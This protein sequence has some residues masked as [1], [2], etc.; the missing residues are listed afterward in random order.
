MEKVVIM[1]FQSLPTEMS[2]DAWKDIWEEEL[3]KLPSR[4][5]Y[6]IVE[7]DG[8][9]EGEK[10]DT[11]LDGAFAVIG[12]R[13]KQG[14]LTDDFFQKHPALKYIGTLSHGFA[15]LDTELLR[16]YEVT[17]TNAIYGANTVAQY[18][19]A[20]LLDICNGVAGNDRYLK[21][22]YWLKRDS[23]YVYSVTRQIELKD[24]VIG[25]IGLG[26]IGYEVAKMAQ[27]FGMKVIS[28]SPHRKQ[29]EEYDFIQQ[30]GLEEVFHCADVITLN[31]ALTDETE[32]LINKDTIRLM[33]D[34]VIIINTSRG[35]LIDEDAL[36]DALNS[37]KVYAA[38]L[39]VLKEEPAAAP[40]SLLLNPYCRVTGHIAWMTKEACERMTFLGL[41]HFCN[42][43]EGK[44]TGVIG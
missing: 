22:D 9:Y 11:L 42:Y 24:K 37:R 26:S 36:T 41:Q 27:G 13:I 34:G 25:I 23:R 19:M 1:L 18:N 35:G 10:L 40:G 14:M 33:K 17:V 16:K 30:V 38:G 20:L 8:T 28:Y 5:Q 6:V 12:I 32:N 2:V 39:D 21:T 44:P 31:C 4:F 15:Q 29:G 43:L 3:R 7:D